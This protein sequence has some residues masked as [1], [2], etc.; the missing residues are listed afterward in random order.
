MASCESKRSHAYSEDLRWRIVWQ[1]EALGYGDAVIAQNLNIDQST[2]RRILQRFFSTGTV[3]KLQYPTDRASR[4]LT[5]P[6][7]LLILH[8]AMGRPGIKLQEIQEELLNS[9]SV[10][11]HISN[12]CRFLQKSG[13]TR[14]KLRITATQRDDFLRQQ[15]ISEVSIYSPEMLIFLDETGT[16]RRNTLRHYGYSMRGKPIVSHQLLIRGDHLSGIAFM[17]VNGL[18]DVKVVRGVTNG[19]VFYSFVEKHLLP[20]LLPYDG[21]NPHSVVIMDNCSIHHLSS[22]VKM[23]EEVGAIVHF[24]PP[25]SPD[26]MPIEFAFSKVKTLMKVDEQTSM[27]VETALLAAF[28]TITPQDCQN[29]ISE[30][31][32]YNYR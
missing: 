28:A 11:I 31:G 3:S 19:D 25:Y 2:V 15:Y 4:K 29:W 10:N 21:K 27:D 20:C 6:A 16:D 22:I 13:F 30:S 8:L 26:F 23:I 1:K 5:D 32:L 24:L 7:Q 14:Q 17:S 12:I 9:L 18:L